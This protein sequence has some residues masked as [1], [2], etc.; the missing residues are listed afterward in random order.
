MTT[1]REPIRPYWPASDVARA[2]L[3]VA[4]AGRSVLHRSHLHH[5]LATLATL[6]LATLALAT[7]A[8]A[9]G[10]ASGVAG[11]QVVTARPASMEAALATTVPRRSVGAPVAALAVG[12]RLTYE[13]RFGAL[14]VGSGQLEVRGLDTVRGRPAWHTVFTIRGGIPLFRVDDRHESWIDAHTFAALRSH[15]AI[16]EGRYRRDRRI[17][18]FP[19]ERVY[20]EGDS[21]GPTS[22]SVAEPLDEGSFLYFVRTLPLVVGE[23]HDFDRYYKPDRNPVSIRVL[24]RE[25]IETPAGVFETVVVQPV[26]KTKGLFSEGGHAEVWLTDDERRLVVQIKARLSV[27]SITLALRDY[28]PGAAAIAA[29]P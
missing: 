8:L 16:R 20:V 4:S 25:R 11:A 6:A 26:I 10:V 3:A 9:T 14:R 22:P 5:A 19:D 17:E 24:R 18:L 2:S 12:E 29:A 13:V 7:L 21:G 27:G 15:Q 23:R 1:M 28:E